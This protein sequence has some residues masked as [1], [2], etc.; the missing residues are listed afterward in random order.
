M[1]N[2]RPG[3]NGLKENRV[4]AV[5]QSPDSIRVRLVKSGGFDLNELVRRNL[6]SLKDVGEACIFRVYGLT[7]ARYSVFTSWFA[8]LIFAST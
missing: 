4:I 8:I 6:W 3:K 7:T 2:C 1:A 5:K